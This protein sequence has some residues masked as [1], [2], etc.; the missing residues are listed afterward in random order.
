[1]G[2]KEVFHP[3]SILSGQTFTLDEQFISYRNAYGKYATVPR[4]A[5]QAVTVDAKGR[6]K[7]VLKLV[8]QGTE[9]ASIEL[10]HPW[11]AKAQRWLM[12]RLGL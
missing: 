12:E 1:M 11:A 9:L 2:K 8:G 3:G 6:G 7:S 5:I 4:K 10:P